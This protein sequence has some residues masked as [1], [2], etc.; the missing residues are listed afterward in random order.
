MNIRQIILGVFILLI[1]AAAVTFFLLI[2]KVETYGPSQTGT[3]QPNTAAVEIV[4][5]RPMQAESVLENLSISP[6]IQGEYSWLDEKTLQFIPTKGWPSGAQVE[7]SLESGS[8]SQ[9]GLAVRQ[10][11]NYSFQISPIMLLYLWPAS[12]SSNIYA[13]DPESGETDQLTQSS[14]VTGFD[15]NPNGQLVYYFVD[16]NINGNDL[17]YLDRFAPIAPETGETT[18][19]ERLLTCQRSLCSTPTVSPDGNLLAYQRNDSEIWLLDLTT[20]ESPEQVS[21]EGDECRMPL[22]SPSG[23]LSY[24]NATEEAYTVLDLKTGEQT[25][26]N[27]L[28]GEAAAWSPGGTAFIAPEAFTNETDILR[29]PSGEADNQ[30]VPQDELEP[31][32]V[33]SA[34][35][36]VYQTN[37]SL[38][39]DLSEGL[40]V[41]DF[42]PAFSPDGRTL[43]FT[44][45][46]LTEE[47]I[48]LGRQVWLVSVQGS[49][50]AGTP[51]QLTDHPDYKYTVLV[52]HP[53]GR[54]LAVVR[55][56]QALLTEPP[57]IWL[58]DLN[59]N[60]TRLV[61][62]GY[63][64]KWTP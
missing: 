57:E 42:A 58:L 59:G 10:P 48:T 8:R 43:A 14:N 30:V 39:Q 38:V 32:R 52:W 62:G 18:P 36:L 27:N 56:N 37:G 61:I 15:I 49:G 25:T 34:H 26:L 50:S 23:D 63:E 47:P 1:I 31:V 17:F 4:F 24:Y 2:P 33:L 22:W 53:N 3:L 28:I 51:K 54:Q 44:R 11:L 13:L 45:R 16:N 9:L 35:L 19:P 60:A 12:G 5:T 46:F 21:P 55:A 7:V 40:L 6:E 64:P 29:G 41:E 20:R